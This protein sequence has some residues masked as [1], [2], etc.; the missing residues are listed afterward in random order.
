MRSE[1]GR[2]TKCILNLKSRM[3]RACTAKDH[4]LGVGSKAKH[5]VGF[6]AK[7][8]ITERSFKLNRKPE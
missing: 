6:S 1:H 2:N 3:A 8:F 5:C 7:M 4:P